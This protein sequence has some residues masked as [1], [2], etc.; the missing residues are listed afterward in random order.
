MRHVYVV[1]RAKGEARSEGER[2][3]EMRRGASGA[4]SVKK[5]GE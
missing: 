3:G 1:A 5:A 2:R 4:R